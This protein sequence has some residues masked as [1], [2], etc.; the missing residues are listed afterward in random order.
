[1]ENRRRE[2]NDEEIEEEESSAGGH[3]GRASAHKSE[4]P[5]EPARKRRKPATSKRKVRV[6]EENDR[7]VEDCV[8]IPR[9]SDA[10]QPQRMD[11]LL[12]NSYKGMRQ[13]R[14]FLN[15]L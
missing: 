10:V 11:R 15:L 13:K 2:K 14:S 4:F 9:A 7:L 12:R 8:S 1:M 5:S 3:G 6:R